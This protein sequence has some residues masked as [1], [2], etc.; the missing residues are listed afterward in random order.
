MRI[1]EDI[2]MNKAINLETAMAVKNDE[3]R[4]YIAELIDLSNTK[5]K[6]LI[7]AIND[8]NH[9]ISAIIL[10]LMDKNTRLVPKIL[11]RQVHNRKVHGEVHYCNS[12]NESFGFVA[13]MVTDDS[14][15]LAK[16][17]EVSGMFHHAEATD[18]AK[19]A[20]AKISDIFIN[21]NI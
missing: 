5:Q 6:Q 12:L 10:D 15:F 19:A 8:V 9:P 11:F 20:I 17:N 14:Y 4:K 18:L 13:L 1:N 7:V 3:A 2:A 21:T 16:A